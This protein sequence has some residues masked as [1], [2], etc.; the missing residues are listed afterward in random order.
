MYIPSTM[1][2]VR[3]KRD[4]APIII[5][6]QFAVESQRN[7]FMG[8]LRIIYFFVQVSPFCFK[9]DSWILNSVK[10]E[11]NFSVW[12]WSQ[13]GTSKNGV[14]AMSGYKSFVEFVCSEFGLWLVVERWIVK[15]IKE[16]FCEFDFSFKE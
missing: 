3:K 15:Y 1:G 6:W 7:K 12:T 16:L 2:W 8:Y 10:T 13:P 14:E 4:T 9:I 11:D 5:H